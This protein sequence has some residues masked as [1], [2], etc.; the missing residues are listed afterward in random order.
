MQKPP[1]KL[2]WIDAVLSL[3]LA[4]S[5]LEIDVCESCSN[6][7]TMETRAW[8]ICINFGLCTIR[9]APTGHRKWKPPPRRRYDASADNVNNHNNKRIRERFSCN[10]Y[11]VIICTWIDG[12]SHL[13]LLLAVQFP[14]RHKIHILQFHGPSCFFVND[15]R[16]SDEMWQL[17]QLFFSSRQ[18][19]C[20]RF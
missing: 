2:W 18:S 11:C 17:N 14:I 13:L 15:L 12:I 9:L 8:F 16:R 4:W 1:A 20:C 19:F 7:V 10:Y 3:G 6:R 5:R